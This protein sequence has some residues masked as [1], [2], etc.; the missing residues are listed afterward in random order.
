LWAIQLLSIVLVLVP[1]YLWGHFEDALAL[2]FVLHAGRHLIAKD[3]IRAALLLSVAISTKQ[4][5]LPLVPLVVFSAPAGRRLRTMVSACALPAALT[6]YV[7]GAD[8]NDAYKALFSPVNLGKVTQGHLSFYATWL[9]SKTSRA[10]RSIGLLLAS[11]LAWRFRRVDRPVMIVAALAV[12]AGLRPFFEAISYSYYW[13]PALF[14]AG[15]TGLAAHRR[16]RLRD[17]LWPVAA[18]VW[19]TP[20]GNSAT[21]GWWW[22]GEIIIVILVFVQVAINCGTDSGSVVPSRRPLMVGEGRA[23]PWDQLI[24]GGRSP[25]LR[26]ILRQEVLAKADK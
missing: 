4:W 5:A 17:W 22:L 8:W 18:M 21:A 7:L 1:C 13:V 11:G 16:F 25:L 9:G 3:N 26:S 6:V 12:V 15:C 20:K 2:T 14:L 10:S 19:A 23:R 24:F